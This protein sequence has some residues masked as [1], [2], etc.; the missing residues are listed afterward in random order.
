MPGVG[1]IIGSFLKILSFIAG[2]WIEMKR[3]HTLATLNADT[4]RIIA[5][6]GGEDKADDWTRATRRILALL[7]IGTWCF[8]NVW[9]ILKT[10][11][12]K[13]SILVPKE[14]SWLWQLFFPTVGQGV[15][16]V[17]SFYI[18]LK[19]YVIVEMIAGFYFTKVGK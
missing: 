10:P 8:I 7:L 19:F 2:K 6:Q 18:L 4:D 11:E 1:F 9:I 14:H 17:S 12:M 13:F 5:I 3:Q 16:E 15:I